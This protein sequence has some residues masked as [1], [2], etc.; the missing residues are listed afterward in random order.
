MPLIAYYR[1]STAE[2]GLSGLG[3][4]AQRAAVLR[5]AEIVGET[6]RAEFTDILSRRKDRPE[7]NAAL[8]GRPIKRHHRSGPPRPFIAGFAHDN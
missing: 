5:Y 3:I 2:Q 8:N 1:V 6:I 7:F 4:E